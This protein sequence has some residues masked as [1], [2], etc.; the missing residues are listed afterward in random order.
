MNPKQRIK[1]L[2]N[3]ISKYNHEY[4]VNNVSLVDDATWD[5]L[6]HELSHL[7][8]QYPELALPNSPTQIV[9]GSVA[10]GFNKV[11]HKN[12]ILSLS[13]A[14]NT[15]D[16]INFDKRVKKA[17]NDPAY[18]LS[19][20]LD[21]LSLILTYEKGFLVTAATR[22]DGTIGE[23]ITNNIK[24]IADVPKQLTEPID[25]VVRGEILMNIDDFE[26]LNQER[27]KNNEPLFQNPRNA[28]AG[29][30]RQ[31][32][33]SITASRSLN[34]I[35]YHLFDATEYGLKSHFESLAYLKKLGFK[36]DET[37]ALV[38][39]VKDI[40]KF[41][42]KCEETRDKLPYEID[43]IVIEVDDFN[44]REEL[45]TTAKY[46]RWATAYKFPAVEAQTK[47]LDIIFTVGRTGQI[48][49]NAV[50]EPVLVAGST[51]ARAS[52]HNEDNIIAKD[53]RIGDTVIIRKAGDVIPEVVRVVKKKGKR[54]G[55]FKMINHC[56]I[57]SEQITRD[58]T[59]A[60]YFC[61][62]D[63]CEI[64]HIKAIS[65]FTSRDA[66]NIV[67]L[68]ESICEYLYDEGY[69]KDIASIYELK[70]YRREL[71][72]LPNMGEKSIDNLLAAIEASKERSFANV[73]YGL[74]IKNIGLKTAKDLVKYFGNINNLMAASEE[75]LEGIH[76]IGKI[77]AKDLTEY[78]SN[79]K[80]IELINKLRDHG[81][82]LESTAGP[83]INNEL[84]N[85]KIVITGS[86]QSMSRNELKDK[87]ERFGANITSSVSS[88]TDYVIVGD[89]PGSKY[90][91]ALE[92][93]IDILDESDLNEYL[94]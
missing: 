46:P 77:I 81:L 39:N 83:I 57:C 44:A 26:Q 27:A 62:S 73:L 87:L 49:P 38:H 68:G 25:V 45:G 40:E 11:T 19:Y 9:G 51:I 50:L 76:E 41:I 21:G 37:T 74:G 72:T 7:E 94:T 82:T 66:M 14:F 8:K 31:L 29:S 35:I 18:L 86:F 42:N 61:K 22:G 34:V 58:E 30:V 28:A 85:K 47:L 70:N 88:T 24:T 16:L 13:N 71:V 67:G 56:P 55:P 1:E 43:G 75:G 64:Q 36:I 48:T 63:N 20:K 15:E 69:L 65:H 84:T 79:P 52:L 6:L 10:A 90:D 91:K 78:F 89:N 32:D 93:K 53:I 4:Y 23:D 60:D 5:S 17:I 59:K 33:A 54:S 12:P 2:V 3:L 92:L 80:H